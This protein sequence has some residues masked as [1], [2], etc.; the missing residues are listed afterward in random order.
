M[1][2]YLFPYRSVEAGSRIVLY[3]AGEVGQD[4]YR[5]IKATGYCE[6]V[7]W[8]DRKASA[9]N[10][11]PPEAI[12]TLASDEYDRVVIAIERADS[13]V[14]VKNDLIGRGVPLH[15]II[16]TPPVAVPL[17]S[18]FSI[19]T[20]RELL[21]DTNR[22]EEE[23]LSYFVKAE[24][25]IHYFESLIE[26]M[27]LGFQRDESLKITVLQRVA[28]IVEDELSTAEMRLVILRLL[29]EADCFDARMMRLYLKS[30]GELHH[31][32]AQ[33]YWL[34]Q[35]VPMIW[36]FYADVLYDDFWIDMQRVIKDYAEEIA[37]SWNPPSCR[38]TDERT[39]CI[40]TNSLY[41]DSITQY[42]SPIAK[43]LLRRD[44]R[45]H[46]INL[47]PY[48]YDSGANFLLP[49]YSGSL[50]GINA[51]QYAQVRNYYPEPI[52]LHYSNTETARGRQQEVLDLVSG[53][54]PYAILD[55]TDESG[56]ISHYYYRHY[57]TIYMPM[58]KWRESS[59]FF[60]R[61]AISNNLKQEVQPPIREDQVLSVP[62]FVEYLH[63]QKEF[64]RRDYGFAE[65]DVLVVTVG[66]RLDADIGP[67]LAE[68]FCKEITANP[69]V[70]WICVGPNEHSYIMDR[71]AHLVGKQIFMWGFERDL[72]GLYGMCDIYLNPQRFGGG[73]TI[74]W[75]M[76]HGLALASPL[77]A[78]AGMWYA[79]ERLAVR[80]DEELASYVMNLANNP[81][82][83]AHNQAV[84]RRKASEWSIEAYVD[85]LI[86]GMDEI[87]ER[88][89]ASHT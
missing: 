80:N 11:R 6:V 60:H 32:S 76:Q 83:L 2:Q 57:P 36:V 29:L 82:A 84:M 30:I 49:K 16:D 5:Q 38:K 40:L 46:V 61:I 43:E 62:L 88:F 35:D 65:D 69:K 68:R 27:K 53:I 50:P 89:Q 19:L 24:G 77:G 12:D 51:D 23:L 66:K 17:I 13:M 85:T 64:K 4:Y 59:S 67:A 41:P 87:A 28:E 7:L 22:V 81:E 18:R 34:I 56:L 25:R 44:Y 37:L 14:H 54:N 75:A 86:E 45:I 47:T 20:L 15:K 9:S 63:P 70:K 39:V 33:K 8:L 55:L 48:R 52:E 58:R 3:A 1:N 73:M 74:A 71:F 78:D 72:P 21:E 10:V 31:N 26:E 79:G 42:M